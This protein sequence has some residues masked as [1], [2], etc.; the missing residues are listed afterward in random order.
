MEI[1]NVLLWHF[2]RFSTPFE[3][4]ALESGMLTYT[5]KRRR[6]REIRERGRGREG[7]RGERE[8]ER[9]EREREEREGQ[10]GE[11]AIHPTAEMELSCWESGAAGKHYKTYFRYFGLFTIRKLHFFFQPL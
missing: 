2:L 10:R 4:L 3:I 6:E 5:R 11:K 9:G 7:E 8:G 1:R